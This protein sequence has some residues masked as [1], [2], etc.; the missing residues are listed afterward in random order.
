MVAQEKT[1]V[2]GTLLS[3]LMSSLNIELVHVILHAVSSRTVGTA[4]SSSN[5]Q[6]YQ[7]YDHESKNEFCI[8]SIEIE[9]RD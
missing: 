6:V 5:Y 2:E 3:F 1:S 8:E 9:D 4:K 7:D